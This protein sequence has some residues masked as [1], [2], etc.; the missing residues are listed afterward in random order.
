MGCCPLHLAVAGGHVD[1]VRIL[2]SFAGTD[3]A[4]EDEDGLTPLGQAID[5]GAQGCAE[6]LLRAEGVTKDRLGGEARVREAIGMAEKKGSVA[7][8]VDL[9]KAL[10]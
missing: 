1:V 6:A 2:A 4:A 5:S 3:L 10:L 8:V 7:G 9:L